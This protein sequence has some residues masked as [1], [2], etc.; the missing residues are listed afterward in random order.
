MTTDLMEHL[1]EICRSGGV[2]QSQ[3][4]RR[5]ISVLEGAPDDDQAAA[6]AQHLV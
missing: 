2:R 3:E 4:A 6:T 5:L 1:L